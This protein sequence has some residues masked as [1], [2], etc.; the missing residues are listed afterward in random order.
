MKYYYQTDEMFEEMKESLTKNG[1]RADVVSRVETELFELYKDESL[2]EKPK[3]LEQRGGAYYSEAAV[4]LMNSIYND[5]QDIQTLNVLNGN[6]YDFL[7]ADASIEVNCVVTKQGP[8]P[9]PPRW[10]P[11]HIKGLLHAV[12]TYEQLTIEAAVTGDRGIALQAM[13][14][15]PL[16]PSVRVAKA[17]LDEMLEAN[18]AYL[19][20]FF[21]Q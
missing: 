6:I 1:T 19:P 13:V 16:V 4:N 11:E 15:H 20:H 17:L 5:K 14:H 12:K 21:K 10:I 8:I 2:R 7:P 18:R 9:L 3:Q